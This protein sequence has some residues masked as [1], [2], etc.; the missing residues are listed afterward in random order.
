MKVS[1]KYVQ[2]STDFGHTFQPSWT[3]IICINYYRCLHHCLHGECRV[4]S[5]S[6]WRVMNENLYGEWQRKRYKIQLKFER[7]TQ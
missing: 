4:N 3:S 6:A 5:I 7:K 2:R 1:N